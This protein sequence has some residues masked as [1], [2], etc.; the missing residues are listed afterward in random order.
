VAQATR[1]KDGYKQQANSG[2]IS[3]RLREAALI[4]SLAL[5]TYLLLSLSTYNP[6]DPAWTT[7]GT[8]EVIVNSG[9]IVGAWLADTL[10][11]FFGVPAYLSPLMIAFSGWL[12]FSWGRRADSEGA[13]H[14][15]LIKAVGLVMALFSASGLSTLSLA[16]FIVFLPEGAGGVL[17]QVVGLGFESIFGSSGT[18]L[19]L[20]AILL[21]GITLFTGL[22]WLMVIDRLGAGA[23]AVA[24]IVSRWI[25]EFRHDL[26]SKRN[27]KQREATFIEQNEKIQKQEKIRVEPTIQAPEPSKREEK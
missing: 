18:A 4:L 22:S 19:L 15:W 1:V 27:K 10:L 14:F 8:N 13:L 2:G 20:L 6:T 25:R 3:F 23:I 26:L 21:T 5:A 11:F 12:L 16:K 17:G 9:G 7:T 24:T